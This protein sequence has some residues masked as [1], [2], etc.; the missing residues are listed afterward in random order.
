[1]Q[2]DETKP[3]CKRCD[4]YGTF[5]NYDSQYSDLQPLEKWAG[6]ILILQ[7]SVCLKD[8]PVFGSINLEASSPEQTFTPA[9]LIGQYQFSTR[10]FNLLHEF[11]TK[12]FYTF[13][14]GK[15]QELYRQAY[16]SLAQSVS[17]RPSIWHSRSNPN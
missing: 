2:C 4:V 1:M 15:N 6:G 8:S 9:A 11:Q 16:K 5:C 12:T 17:F 10:D 13:A 14:A 7:P 3:M